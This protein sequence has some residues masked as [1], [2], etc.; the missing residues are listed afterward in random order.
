M[1]DPVQLIPSLVLTI[2][3]SELL[4]DGTDTVKWLSP[5]EKATQ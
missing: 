3:K 1:H 4:Q 2:A 5:Q